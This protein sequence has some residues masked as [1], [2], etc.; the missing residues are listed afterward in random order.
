[1]PVNLSKFP[2][3]P[4]VKGV[5]LS[6]INFHAKDKWSMIALEP[7]T[8]VSCIFT[9]NAVAAA[10][11]IVAKQHLSQIKPSHLLINAGNANAATG[12]NGI[13][14]AQSICRTL[15]TQLNTTT[16]AI[17]PFSTGVIGEPLN[18]TNIKN[19]TAKLVAELSDNKWQEVAQAI[20]TTD[21][22]PKGAYRVVEYE[23]T[24]I[25]VAGI[26]KG[27][28]MI[29]PNMATMLGFITTDAKIEK[30]A[31]DKML[32]EIAD[33][34][35]NSISVDSD[36]STNDALVL[37]A[38]GKALRREEI[39]TQHQL[40]NPIYQAVYEVALELAQ[41]IVRDGEGATK[42]I[43]INVK[44]AKNH[45]IAKDTAYSIANSPL[46]KTAC[47]AEDANWGRILMAIGKTPNIG[48]IS[49]LAVS[50]D[51]LSVFADGTIDAQY[52][53]EKG[54]K[55]MAQAE[56]TLNI[57]LNQGSSKATV[58]TSDLSHEYVSINADYRS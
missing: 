9:Q 43:T 58:F 23:G 38:T 22:Q 54:A 50:L 3:I 44:S 19:N 11:V 28:G 51:D 33:K 8:N 37:A 18:L 48:D 13:L 2:N 35:F 27:S 40:Y 24:K 53:E 52:T 12:E 1:M 25:T 32:H 20:T 42:F 36:T 30:A 17:L 15:A 55:I 34:T 41:T 49:K 56:I 7:S 45:T 6:A 5:K 57:Y 31:L 46:V 26:A 39:D 10:P 14:Q 16:E 47:F 21:T 4:E 29:C